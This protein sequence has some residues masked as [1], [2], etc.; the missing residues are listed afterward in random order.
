[1]VTRATFMQFADACKECNSNKGGKRLYEWIRLARKDEV[2]RIAEGKY[3][4]LLYDLHEK[5]CTLNVDKNDLKTRLCDMRDSCIKEGHEGELTVYCF[6][7]IF[8]RN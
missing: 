1:M 4:K 6:E 3:L 8:N 2:P 5:S 7:G